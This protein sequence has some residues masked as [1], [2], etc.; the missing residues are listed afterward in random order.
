ML[1]KRVNCVFLWK[2]WWKIKTKERKKEERE[3][4]KEGRKTSSGNASKNLFGD[5][6]LKAAWVKM[7]HL[8]CEC[9]KT[10]TWRDG[11]AF[12]AIWSEAYLYPVSFLSYKEIFW[13]R[14]E[15]WWF[16]WILGNR[17]GIWKLVLHYFP[18]QE[19]FGQDILANVLIVKQAG[20]EKFFRKRT[21]IKSCQ[22]N[23]AFLNTLHPSFLKLGID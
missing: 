3:R 7:L 2:I 15:H 21:P 1:Y 5:K 20:T 16:I 18:I 17:W 22:N 23:K 11:E 4:R 8:R 14:K 10:Y 9:Y 19:C 6:L 13:Y 12:I